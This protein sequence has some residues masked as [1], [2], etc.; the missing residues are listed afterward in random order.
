MNLSIKQSINFNRWMKQYFD[1]STKLK[2]ATFKNSP[3]SQEAEIC[4]FYMA[5]GVN[6]PAII[7]QPAQQKI[8]RTIS[9]SIDQT[10]K[11]SNIYIKV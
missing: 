1:Q 6:I 2:T 3:A 7:I 10:I 8:N 5:F 11:H 9:K 4:R